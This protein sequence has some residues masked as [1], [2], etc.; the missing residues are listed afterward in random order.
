[1]E[2]GNSWLDMQH[3]NPLDLRRSVGIGARVFMPMI[4]I[5]GFDYGYGFDRVDYYGNPD[6]KWKMHFVFGRS[7]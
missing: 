7:F 2:A 6:P 4:G 3:T 5:I 1:A